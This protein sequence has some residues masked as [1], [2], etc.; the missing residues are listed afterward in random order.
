MAGECRKSAPGR[1]L[2]RLHDQELEEALVGAERR[3]LHVGVVHPH[4]MVAGLE[5]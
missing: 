3:F 5:V 4:L 2:A 1:R